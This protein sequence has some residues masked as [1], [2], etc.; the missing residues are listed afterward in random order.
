MTIPVIHKRIF[1]GASFLFLLLLFLLFQKGTG[2]FMTAS[3]CIVFMVTALMLSVLDV[4]PFML[5]LTASL[6]LAVGMGLQGTGVRIILPAEPLEGLLFVVYLLRYFTGRQKP[7][8]AFLFHPVTLS[9]VS[10]LLFSFIALLFSTMPIVSFKS[11]LVKM[12]YIGVYYFLFAEIIRENPLKGIRYFISYGFLLAVVILYALANHA[13]Y[14]FSKDTSGIVALPFYADHTIYSACIAFV[15][16][17]F[18]VQGLNEGF[19]EKSAMKRLCYL[20]LSLLFVAGI[21]FSLCRAT[22]LSVACGLIMLLLLFLKV[23]PLIL[24]SGMLALAVLAV[25][26][27][28]SLLGIFKQNRYDSNARGAGIE[29]QTKSITNIS[30]DQSNGER[31]NRWKCALRMFARKPVTGF[32]PGTFQFKYLSFQRTSEMTRI[33]VTNPNN[34]KMGHGGTAHSEYLLSLSENGAGAFLSFLMIILFTVSIAM[35]NVQRSEDKA[36][37]LATAAMLI[38]LV[39][40]LVHGFFNNFLDTDKAAFLF[41]SSISLITVMDIRIKKNR[42]YR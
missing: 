32:G 40:Y 37:R 25:G 9:I 41:W 24:F 20:L 3:G 10:L 14:Y 29:E 17:V 18:I 23:K 30:N 5:L 1:H 4:A 26:N 38:G 21:F 42:Q 15:L 36:I 33:S 8:R 35:K 13:G 39:S 7:D 2:Y 16:P 19:L 11:F 22:W 34:I 27:S 28:E 6:P 12:I 31:L